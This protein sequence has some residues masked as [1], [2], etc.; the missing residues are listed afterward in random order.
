MVEL[1]PVEI[2][3]FPLP[4]PAKSLLHT[5]TL[6]TDL[7]LW[8]YMKKEWG[9][10]VYG[11]KH[12]SRESKQSPEQSTPLHQ[13][14]KVSMDFKAFPWRNKAK[15]KGEKNPKTNIKPTNKKPHPE[16]TTHSNLSGSLNLKRKVCKVAGSEISIEG[17]E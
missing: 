16:Q 4:D 5:E 17:I 1:L 2:P 15:E 10:K 9:M 13:S 12:P 3:S 7:G 14:F 6:P 11:Q 8:E